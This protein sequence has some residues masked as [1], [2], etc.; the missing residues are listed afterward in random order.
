MYQLRNFTC[1]SY[2]YMMIV[3][4]AYSMSVWLVHDYYTRNAWLSVMGLVH[5]NEFVK[6]HWLVPFGSRVFAFLLTLHSG[7]LSVSTY[8]LRSWSS[9]ICSP[10]ANY[11]CILVLN[12]DPHSCRY[13][14]NMF[15]YNCQTYKQILIIMINWMPSF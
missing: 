11:S 3:L 1:Y 5:R 9:Q 2:W 13:D 15:F 8:L 14:Q 6:W 12:S 4:D 10:F 7:F